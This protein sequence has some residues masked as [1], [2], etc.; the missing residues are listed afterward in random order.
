MQLIILEVVDER[1]ESLVEV[2]VDYLRLFLRLRMSCYYQLLIYAEDL[3][4]FVGKVGDE[5]ESFVSDYFF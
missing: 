5:L 4:D 1:A 3:A 2:F